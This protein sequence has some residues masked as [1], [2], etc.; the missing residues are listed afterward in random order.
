MCVCVCEHGSSTQLT[1]ESLCVCARVCLPLC[2]CAYLEENKRH[3]NKAETIACWRGCLGRIQRLVR[4]VSAR[5]E[6]V[7][8]TRID[9]FGKRIARD[10]GLQGSVMREK[11][12]REDGAGE[13]KKIHGIRMR[14]EIFS[15]VPMH[16]DQ[17][18][19][20]E[21]SSRQRGSSNN[22]HTTHTHTHTHT[23]RGFCGTSNS[24]SRVLM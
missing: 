23:C 10:G 2:V 20:N 4:P 9:A 8:K 6:P 19:E 13:R 12:G 7:E 15:R 14:I 21:Y 18:Q 17:K 22:T 24:S 16:S 1:A 3:R 5:T 11:R